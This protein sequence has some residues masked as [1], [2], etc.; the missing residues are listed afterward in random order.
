MSSLL[1]LRRLRSGAGGM[2]RVACYSFMTVAASRDADS[3]NDCWSDIAH[4]DQ[5]DDDIECDR[6][7]RRIPRYRDRRHTLQESHHRR[8]RE[9]YDGV[10]QRNLGKRE[11]GIAADIAAAASA[12]RFVTESVRPGLADPGEFAFQ[13]QAIELVERKIED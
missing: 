2:V 6:G 9:H 8:E 7:Q 3:D 12:A 10:I 13:L 4:Q 11:V 5:R 1:L